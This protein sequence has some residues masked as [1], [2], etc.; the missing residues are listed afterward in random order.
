MY[1]GSNH[2]YPSSSFTPH[3]SN[4]PIP[5]SP[6]RNFVQTII[7]TTA[8]SEAV[9]IL[10]LWYVNK[11]RRK[12]KFAQAAAGSEY[13]L[14]ATGM[15][16]ANK[17]L[18]D[19]TYTSRTWSSLTSLPLHEMNLME[20]EFLGALEHRVGITD[21][22]YLK[23]TAYLN[24]LAMSINERN[25]IL[26]IS[27]VPQDF[28]FTFQAPYPSPTY[29]HMPPAPVSIRARSSSPL[30]NQARRF[31]PYD[32]PALQQAEGLYIPPPQVST[33]KRSAEESFVE[34]PNRAIRRVRSSQYDNISQQP[35]HLL[36]NGPAGS[37]R[38]RS[39]VG[40]GPFVS[41]TRRGE[42]QLF[43]PPGPGLQNF[44]H[45][46]T[47][48]GYGQDQGYLQQPYSYQ[49]SEQPRPEVS[50]Q[51]VIKSGHTRILKLWGLIR[52]SLSTR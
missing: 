39:W 11:I 37:A 25:S 45:P 1:L 28:P 47:P 24:T 52:I 16:L 14:C 10:S 8:V 43:V 20:V 6:F 2:A 23:W 26:P 41:R 30:R 21:V 22:D 38:R 18:D 13:R 27:I 40:N 35:H 3:L 12:N 46:N 17:Y 32:Y 33:R 19:N 50:L 49:M 7:N 5:T 4:L 34:D 9:L 48:M 15:M 36:P 31:T 51:G 44:G 42:G 29:N